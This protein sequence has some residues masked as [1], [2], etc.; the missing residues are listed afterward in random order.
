M[1]LFLRISNWFVYMHA[2]VCKKW[3]GKEDWASGTREYEI[4]KEE[5]D[6]RGVMHWGGQKKSKKKCIRETQLSCS[7]SFLSRQCP[8]ISLFKILDLHL[9]QG[10]GLGLQ[11]EEEVGLVV[12]EEVGGRQSRHHGMQFQLVA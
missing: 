10:Q 5:G 9:E 6:E 7:Y 3:V 1:L 4:T 11:L 12:V 2:W 8:I